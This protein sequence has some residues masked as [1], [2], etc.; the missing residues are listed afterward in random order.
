MDHRQFTERQI[1][2]LT[3]AFHRGA[4]A[5][6]RA[7]GDWLAATTMMSIDGVDQC[8]LEQATEIL[9]DGTES[10]CM[11]LM[12][13]QGTLS[14]H[15]LLAFD[16]A[17]GLAV[18]DLLLGLAVGTSAEWGQVELSSALET[19]NITGSAYL[20][21]IAGDLSERLGETVTLIPTPPAFYRDFAESLLETAFLDQAIAVSRIVFARAK[22]ELQGKPLEWKFLL[23]PDP[24]S[25][26]RL[27]EILAR[28]P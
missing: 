5:A 16:D 22:F 10:I 23:I 15:M 18:S 2:Q 9:G 4:E 25:L 24:P 7:L 14:G 28:L 26:Q 1:E 12:E 6:S 21:G 13:M 17:S 11:C 20:N 19:M 8:S 27:S 3:K